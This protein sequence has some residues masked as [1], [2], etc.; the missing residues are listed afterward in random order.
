MK[1]KTIHNVAVGALSGALPPLGGWAAASGLLALEAWLLGA[2][3]FFWQ[4]VHFF[5]I[6]WI[7][8]EDYA[9]GGHCMLPCHD[10]K[11][12]RVA[13]QIMFFGILLCVVSLIFFVID[14]STPVYLV[15]AVCLN[16][17]L[18]DCCWTFLRF[19]DE[20]HAKQLARFSQIYLALLLGALV[21]D[22]FLFKPFL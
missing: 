15:F 11:G 12:K 4:F 8:R 9:R 13:F 14:Y 6:A 21:M 7:Y 16:I 5:P 18:L 22:A 3:L 2:V 17:S 19:C 20:I 10:P 1:R